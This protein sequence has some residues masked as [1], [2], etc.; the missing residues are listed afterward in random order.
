MKFLDLQDFLLAFGVVSLCAG[1]GFIYWPAALVLFGL[2]CL[3]AVFLIE[4]T[5]SKATN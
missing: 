1:V 2:L 5:K 4:K 3:C